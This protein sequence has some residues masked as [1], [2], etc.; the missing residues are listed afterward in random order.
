MEFFL[1]IM[2]GI[3]ISASIFFVVTAIIIA[4]LWVQDRSLEFDILCGMVRDL[5]TSIWKVEQILDRLEA[6]VKKLKDSV[7]E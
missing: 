5:R 7:P 6:S 4:G 1:N 2:A 3:G